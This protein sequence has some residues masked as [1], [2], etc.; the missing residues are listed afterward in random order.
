MFQKERK[1]EWFVITEIVAT[2]NLMYA[3]IFEFKYASSSWVNVTECDKKYW[4]NKLDIHE[5][6]TFFNLITLIL[7]C[8]CG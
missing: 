7:L 4:K 2:L 5:T 3:I 6:K 8:Y 1:K